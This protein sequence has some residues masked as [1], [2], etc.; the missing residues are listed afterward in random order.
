MLL[1]IIYDLKRSVDLRL[2]LI[3]SA[4]FILD[5]LVFNLSLL[6]KHSQNLQ[7]LRTICQQTEF[8]RE[9]RLQDYFPNNL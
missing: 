5:D 6:R 9:M 1:Q 8:S 4:L 3:T 2:L 7:H